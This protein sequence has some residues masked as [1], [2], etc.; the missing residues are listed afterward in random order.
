MAFSCVMPVKCGRLWIMCTGQVLLC[1]NSLGTFGAVFVSG[2]LHV[3]DAKLFASRPGLRL[4]K[5]DTSGSVESTVMYRDQLTQ[6]TENIVLLHDAT[7]EGS[8]VTRTEDRQFGRLLL[9]GDTC[10]LTYHGSC[11]YVLDYTRNAVVFYHRNVGPITDVAVCNDE[12]YILRNFAHRPLIRLSQQPVF[13]SI[14]STKGM[15]GAICS[16]RLQ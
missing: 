11:L 5:S 8:A 4:W 9:Y 7:L 10:L 13:D 14:S 6:M 2:S 12:V 1:L 16:S 15:I 3:S